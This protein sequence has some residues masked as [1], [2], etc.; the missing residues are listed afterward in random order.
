M[1]TLPSISYSI[2]VRLDLPA[3]AT[4]VSELTSAIERDGG[5]VTA[6]DVTASGSDTLRIDVTAAAADTEHAARLVETMRAVPGVE[7]G[8]VSDR[9]FLAHLGGKLSIESRGADPQP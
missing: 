8:K 4:A 7:I 5:A 2:T 3:R 1:A 6:L 9:T